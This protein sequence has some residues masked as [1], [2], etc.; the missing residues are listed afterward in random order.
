MYSTV[1]AVNNTPVH[2]GKLL[3]VDLESSQHKEIELITTVL[4]VN[5]AYCGNHL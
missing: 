3:R 5:G 1:T 4:N 2:T